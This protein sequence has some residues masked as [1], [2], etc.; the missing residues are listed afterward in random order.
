[1]ICLFGCF[2]FD[3]C[4]R[5]CQT[6]DF[7]PSGYFHAYKY[8]I[9]N[10][11]S[12]YHVLL[13]LSPRNLYFGQVRMVLSWNTPNNLDMHMI[14]ATSTTLCDVNTGTVSVQCAGTDVVVERTCAG[15]LSG[16]G[17]TQCA[18]SILIAVPRTTVYTL[19]VVNVNNGAGSA[20]PPITPNIY[21]TGAQV[22]L[23]IG[24]GWW[25]SAWPY[26]V[27][28][29]PGADPFGQDPLNEKTYWT[30]FCARQYS[31]AGFVPINEFGFTFDLAYA[32]P[33]VANTCP[34]NY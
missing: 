34:H 7:L 6:C 28:P 31:W 25:G 21:N 2:P 15:G 12:N 19:S 13:A 11:V 22:D 8:L 23:Y 14:Y 33:G 10:G 20:T 18:E 3:L 16:Q 9:I 32:M 29:V 27:L 24:W 5:L 30:V 1:L 26:A 17:G 4:H